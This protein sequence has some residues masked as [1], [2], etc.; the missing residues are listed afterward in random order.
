MNAR[1][2]IATILSFL[3]FLTW[4]LIAPDAR[5]AIRWGLDAE[6]GAPY[7]LR[8]PEDPSRLRGFEV[9][10]AAALGKRLGEPLS[11]VQYDF[12]SLLVGLE[13]G[14]LD[15]VMNGIEVTKDRV[16]R[17][18][19]S[20][21]YY[22]Y[23]LQ[24]V[25]RAADRRFD[26]LEGCL[27]VRCVVGTL[28]DT[29]AERLLDARGVTKKVYDGNVEPYRDLAL[30]RIDAVLLDLP[31]ATWYARPDPAL[32]FAGPP[33]DR[34]LYAIA[35][36]KDQEELARRV[37]AAL[38]EMIE[39]GE[40]RRILEDWRLWDD[41]Q[42]ALA[43]SATKG[44]EAEATRAWAFGRYFPLLLR[45]LWTTI[46]L[47]IASMVVAVL[48][49]LPI[50]VARLWGPAPIRALA[51]I[52]VEVFRGIPVLLLLF[53]LYYGLP[54]VGVRLGPISA[55]VLGFGLNYAAYEAEIYRGAIGAVPQGQWEA[56]AS[57]G[58]GRGL[59]FRRVVLPQALRL[60][61]P[62]MT[63]D[64]VALF[65]D[66]SLVSVIA[67]VELTKQYQIV[68]KSSMQYL[69]IGLVTAALYLLV[70]SPLGVVSRWLEARVSQGAA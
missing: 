46:G 57:L 66:T 45:G 50:A 20:R 53:F 8:D 58:M 22:V 5:A 67:V 25:T 43:D 7:A 35:F 47:S 16:A 18:R 9:E 1:G 52:Y 59:T 27:A 14:D 2:L 28:G 55:A 56:A 37:D 12:G 36:R 49:G 34:G 19:F 21:P 40:L 15:L 24:L 10:I 13:R 51:V 69:E 63:N 62:P 30:G 17:V 11:P 6:G 4:T 39:S 29:A 23:R 33:V 38:G 42:L 65:K 3:T 60:V 68:A 61:L 41:E 70:S 54:G 26:A 32:R 31:I 48:L 44:A 64:F